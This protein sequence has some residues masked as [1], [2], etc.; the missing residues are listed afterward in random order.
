MI[1]F[2]REAR[3]ARLP[4]AAPASSQPF[5]SVAEHD[6]AARLWNLRG[7]RTG[8]DFPARLRLGV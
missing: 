5:Q 4:Q 6:A 7:H 2:H 1:Q 8:P 3:D